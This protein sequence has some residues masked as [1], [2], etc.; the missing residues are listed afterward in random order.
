[1]QKKG[2]TAGKKLIV[3]QE[4]RRETKDFFLRGNSNA[5]F[6]TKSTFIL[7]GY[8]ASYRLQFCV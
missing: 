6:Q 5:Y 8:F 1:M 4:E 3:I 7:S 2:K